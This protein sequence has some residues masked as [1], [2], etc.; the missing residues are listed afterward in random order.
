MS[1]RTDLALILALAAAAACRNA[2]APQTG[3]D[4]VFVG[5]TLAARYMHEQYDAARVRETCKVWHELFAPDGRRISKGLGGE[6][7]HHRGLFFAFH[8][9][10]NAGRTLDF[11]HCR[12]GESQRHM[13]FCD[14]AGLGV[15]DGFQ[16]VAIDW[17]D[18]AGKA[19]VHERR[20]LRASALDARTWRFD[21]VSE[22]RA[23]EP[24]NLSGDPHH[25]GCQFRALA[26]FAEKG[27]K[28]VSFVRPPGAV[29]HANDEWTECAWM[30]MVLP[31]D[32]EPVT[33]LRVE[34]PG[35]PTPVRWSS[36]DYGR[37][38][39]T[40]AHALQPG[41]PLRIG[42]AWV[43]ALGALGAAQCAELATQVNAADGSGSGTVR[44]R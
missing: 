28:K 34:L 39:A 21:L 35:N 4:D 11:W 9:T 3:R 18:A 27:G 7:E 25:S 23:D 14:A 43:V 5:S 15:D 33:V 24:V 42:Y 8:K 1:R 2:P 19:V 13:G 22:L 31:L 44:V 41:A 12:N 26:E 32:G 38:G 6:F 17:T 20:A 36:R 10:A 37:F 30:A 40:F 16:V 29:A